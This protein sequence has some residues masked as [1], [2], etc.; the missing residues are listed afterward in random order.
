MWLMHIG[1]A[2]KTR[3]QIYACRENF[4]E[5]FKPALFAEPLGER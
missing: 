1:R 4:R 3:Q 2:D 5:P